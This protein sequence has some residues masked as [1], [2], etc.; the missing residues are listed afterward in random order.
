MRTAE[1]DSVVGST[2]RSLTSLCDAH[3][4]VWLR[5]GKHTMESDSAVG[6]T[7]W[8][9][10]RHLVP[11]TLRCDAHHW[12]WLRG[13]MHTTELDSPVGCT[14]RSSTLQWNTHCGVRLIRKCPYF[15][16]LYFLRLWTP[17][18]RKTSEVKRFLEQ[19]MT[20]SIN[21]VLISIGITAK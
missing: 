5:G 14:P 17:V 13:G 21:F 7:Q 1:L 20:Y 16:F 4:G 3:R 8:S 19:F 15:V 6:C 2:Q 10:L 12:A 9:F 18:F 11:L